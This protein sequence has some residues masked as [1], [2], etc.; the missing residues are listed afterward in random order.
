[1]PNPA[2]VVEQIIETVAIQGLLCMHRAHE[3]QFGH[4]QLSAC[5]SALGKLARLAPA[6]QCW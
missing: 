1:M 2:A 4:I 3:S 5:W 6:E